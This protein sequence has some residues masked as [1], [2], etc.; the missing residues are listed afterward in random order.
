MIDDS[1]N[2]GFED[3]VTGL[4]HQGPLAEAYGTNEHFV[5]G[6]IVL[7]S[8][9]CVDRL[10]VEVGRNPLVDGLHAARVHV[11]VDTA[12]CEHGEISDKVGS[13]NGDVQVVPECEECWAVL[14][15][16]FDEECVGAI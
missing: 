8:D 11:A 13:E 7:D 14:E 3:R 6:V 9:N 16:V 1:R 15:M 5:S 2:Y 10:F 4:G 12:V